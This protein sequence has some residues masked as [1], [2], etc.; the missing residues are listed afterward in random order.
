MSELI[1]GS[2]ND[3]WKRLQRNIERQN[4]LDHARRL[5]AIRA[6]SHAL[7]WAGSQAELVALVSGWYQ[8]G[9]I[10]AASVEDALDKAAIHFVKPDGTL[11]LRFP[12]PAQQA[13]SADPQAQNHRQAFVLPLLE[14]KGWSTG[15]WAI[16]SQVSPATAQ[17]YLANTTK[18]YRSTR[19]KLAKAL[20]VPVQQ[21]PH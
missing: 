11:V 20:G 4:E 13:T 7:V 21:L 2:S 12:A 3:I 9:L 14:K 5:A 15:D 16:E 17:D 18:P 8:S 19:A 6:Q 10:V 1:G